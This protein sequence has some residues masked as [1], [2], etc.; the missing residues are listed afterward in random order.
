MINFKKILIAIC[1][2]VSVI[3]VNAKTT[4]YLFV[5]S[6]MNSDLTLMI[7]GET[8]CKLNTPTIKT[9]SFDDF[10]MPLCTSQPGWIEI[11]FENEGKVLLAIKMVYNNPTDIGLDHPNYFAEYLLNMQDQ[12]VVY[13]KFGPK[14]WSD[15]FITELKKGKGKKELKK[16]KYFQLPKLVINNE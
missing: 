7:D 8:Q 13:L 10:K 5:S 1:I 16:D 11:E 6:L 9:K 4:V 15:V 2:L 12:E 3:S 14:G